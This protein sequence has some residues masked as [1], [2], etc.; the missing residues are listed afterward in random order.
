MINL[1]LSLPLSSALPKPLRTSALLFSPRLASTHHFSNNK[2][3][4]SVLSAAYT[5]YSPTQFDEQSSEDS[6]QMSAEKLKA[7]LKGGEQVVSVMQEMIALVIFL[8]FFPYFLKI[9]FM[10]T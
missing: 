8:S 9:L 6:E 1:T 3:R 7:L 10:M 5:N 2:R 4:S